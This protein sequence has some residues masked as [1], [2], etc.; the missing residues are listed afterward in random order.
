MVY[1]FFDNKTESEVSVDKK[2]VQEFH[3]TVIKKFKRRKVYIRSEDN[4]WVTNLAEMGSLSFKNWGG[5]YL[6][7][8][9][10]VFTWV[11]PVPHVF[12]EIVKK[13]NCKPNKLWIDQGREFNNSLMQNWLDDNDILMY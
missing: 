5:K 12:I 3:K 2:L 10:D 8:V 6:L 1:K 7:C 4:I 13:S 9:I 11:K